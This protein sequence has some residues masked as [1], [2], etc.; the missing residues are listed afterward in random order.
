MPALVAVRKAQYALVTVELPG[1]PERNAG[2]LLLDPVSD[3]LYVKF[4]QDWGQISDPDDA[5]VLAELARDFLHHSR[6]LGGEKFLRS[7]EDV[8]SN[9][10][11][12]RPREQ[13]AVGDFEK[14]L[15]RLYARYFEE[16][17]PPR[18]T[19]VPFQ[20]HLPLYS[21]RAAA[22][23]F[24]EDMEV[25]PEAWLAAPEGLRLTEGTYAVH[26]AGRSMEPL[27]PDGSMAVF[28]AP[29]TGSCQGKILLIWNCGASQ[30]GG[31]FTVKRYTSLKR[32]NEDG[33]RHERIRLEPV[34][35]EYEAWDLNS[36]EIA[37]GRYRVL[38]EFLR[39]IPCEELW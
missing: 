7:L 39:V 19:P 21:L 32:E 2:L 22:G 15:E 27:I 30:S 6:I 5:E 25:E 12:I 14:A 37:T 29:V 13:A 11:R 26:V 38:G 20:T 28:R 16:A 17:G 9:T 4:R 3:R 35:P 34:N 18:A 36:S 33:W 1:R 24:G 10:L 23:R 31:E 8:L